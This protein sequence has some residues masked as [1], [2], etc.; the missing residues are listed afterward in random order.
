MNLKANPLILLPVERETPVICF[1][2]NSCDYS[3]ENLY[4]INLKTCMA[5]GRTWAKGHGS[6]LHQLSNGCGL[7]GAPPGTLPWRG[8]ISGRFCEKKCTVVLFYG[9][10]VALAMCLCTQSLHCTIH[11][12]TMQ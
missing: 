5:I 12:W 11:A 2:D 9:T 8:T 6:G 3:V 1:G 4:H 10:G 7:V